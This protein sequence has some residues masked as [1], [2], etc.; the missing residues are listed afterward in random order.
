MSD[1]DR[2]W[3]LVGDAGVILGKLGT[4]AKP[5]VDRVKEIADSV[6]RAQ[7]RTEELPSNTP[8]PLGK[9]DDDA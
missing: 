7:S 5:F 6:W 3:G 9:S 4:D 8:T 2:F 1:L